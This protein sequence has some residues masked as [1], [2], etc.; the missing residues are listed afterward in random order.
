MQRR[1]DLPGNT[2]VSDTPVPLSS[3]RS[4]SANI[5]CAA[6]VAPYTAAHGND[7][8]AAPDDTTTMCPCA[9]SSRC[10]S[11]WWT[12][13][14]VPYQLMSVIRRACSSGWSRNGP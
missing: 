4:A 10:G 14:S 5:R 7:R 3:C 9:A 12:V 13:Y 2:V 11:P 8:S 1:R 6:F